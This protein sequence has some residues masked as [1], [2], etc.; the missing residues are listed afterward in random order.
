MIPS[1]AAVCKFGRLT[2]LPQ[3]LRNGITGNWDLALDTY[4]AE[5]RVLQKKRGE[6]SNRPEI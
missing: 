2:L 5:S 1:S 4:R 3:F 6:V